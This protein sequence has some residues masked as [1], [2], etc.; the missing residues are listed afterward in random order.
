ME[1]QEK[2]I[3]AIE[4]ALPGV[5]SI[6]VSKKI[7]A[8][9]QE[10]TKMGLDPRQFY[11]KIQNEAEDGQIAVSGGSGFIVDKTGIILT[12]KHVVADKEATYKAVMGKEKYDLEI[13]GKDPVSDIAILKLIHPRKNISTIKLG[14]SKN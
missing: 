13:L 6:V 1:Y 8:V 7:E 14:I 2:I 3:S 9:E 4:K 10:M 5:L 12:N 11:A